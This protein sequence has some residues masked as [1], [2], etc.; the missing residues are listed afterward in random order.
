MTQEKQYYHERLHERVT[1]V[2][3]PN[4]SGYVIVRTEDNRLVTT[5]ESRLKP[6]LD[7][8]GDEILKREG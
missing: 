1:I 8:S 4:E 2:I 7:M 5:H 6:L 3:A